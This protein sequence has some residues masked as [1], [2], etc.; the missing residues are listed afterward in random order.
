MLISITGSILA[1]VTEPPIGIS[2]SFAQLRANESASI[3]AHSV[4]V[5]R[6]VLNLFCVLIEYLLKNK[7]PH[8]TNVRA[9]R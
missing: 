7:L 5:V 4:R 8:R 9:V 3:I 1:T 2:K 6:F